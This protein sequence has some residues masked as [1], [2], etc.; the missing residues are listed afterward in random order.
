MVNKRLL[1]I[2]N[3]IGLACLAVAILVVGYCLF[4]DIANSGRG[5]LQTDFDNDGSD[6]EY[7]LPESDIRIYDRSE[8]EALS[9]QE[10]YYAINE[11]YA[12]HG[13]QFFADDLAKHFERCSW[14]E[15]LYSPEEYDALPSQLNDIEQAN[16]DS[17][18][19]IRK[20]RGEE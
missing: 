8:L 13:R 12:R 7:V 17:M 18:A 3:V 16:I 5:L 1:P 9:S 11:V 20:E 6:S 10:L 14:Y 2:K 4:A 19:E 15:P